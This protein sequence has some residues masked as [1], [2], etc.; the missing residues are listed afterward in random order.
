MCEQLSEQIDSARKLARQVA[1]LTADGKDAAARG[2]FTRNW[3]E[4]VPE[5]PL[6]FSLLLDNV[7]DS[8][9]LA[10]A[11]RIIDGGSE[12]PLALRRMPGDGGWQ[13][14]V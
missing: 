10:L 2:V 7:H 5:L 14:M 12:L 1:D 6:R 13:L 8:V 3:R 9:A 4:S 11:R